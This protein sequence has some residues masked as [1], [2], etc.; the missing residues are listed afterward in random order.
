MNF[1][2]IDKIAAGLST[3]CGCTYHAEDGTACASS[4]PAEGFEGR[5]SRPELACNHDM[6]EAIRQGK[7]TLEDI[8]NHQLQSWVRDTLE[9]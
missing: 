1:E 7:M 9:D 5:C 8:P 4:K 3:G 6:A 2:E